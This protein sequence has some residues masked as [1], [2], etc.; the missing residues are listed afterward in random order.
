MPP[1]P[2]R[3][4]SRPQ[5]ESSSGTNRNNRSDRN[6]PKQSNAAPDSGEDIVK[7]MVNKIDKFETGLREY[8]IRDLVNHTE[9]LG[10]RLAQTLKTNQIRKFLDAVNRLKSLIRLKYKPEVKNFENVKSE[11]E[12]KAEV[13]NSK[14]VKSG[15]E[16]KAEVE[17]SEN[18]KSGGEQKPEIENFETIKSG[19]QLLRPQLAY[20]AARQ[21]GVMDLKQV[22]EAAI[23]KINEPEDFDRFVQMTESII[24]YHK[25]AGGKD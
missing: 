11:A 16:Q 6:Q 18:V 17:N 7:T 5:T 23:K 15:G 14:N 3:P 1:E 19:V 24:A 10:S 4:V 8:Q 22:M 12:Q 2:N 13:E 21:R 9:V 20:A 25:A